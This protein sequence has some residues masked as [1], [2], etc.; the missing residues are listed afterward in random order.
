MLAGFDVS[1]LICEHSRIVTDRGVYVCP[2]LIDEPAAR[3]GGSLLDSLKPFAIRYGA[4]FTC[5]QYGAIC[6]NP[7]SGHSAGLAFQPD[8]RASPQRFRAS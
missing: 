7:S 1:Q 4:C 2:I 6:S 8:L 3:L 5:Y